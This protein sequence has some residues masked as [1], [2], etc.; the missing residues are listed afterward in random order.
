[1]VRVTSQS[2]SAT[3]HNHN[4]AGGCPFIHSSPRPS[5]FETSII[6]TCH[7]RH[8]QS[9]MLA[10][11]HTLACH[12]T[13]LHTS[14]MGCA[15]VHQDGSG[16]TVIGGGR[17]QLFVFMTFRPCSQPTSSLIP[18]NTAPPCAGSPSQ[19]LVWRNQLIQAT[20][21]LFAHYTLPTVREVQTVKGCIRDAWIPRPA[22][23][24]CLSPPACSACAEKA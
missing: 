4:R 10:K 12:I 15:T 14:F 24:W 20:L 5:E 21:L 1:M 9:I 19:Y 8:G 7:N 22:M 6:M 3:G 11:E 2:H 23:C 17:F 16:Q 18:S 13:R